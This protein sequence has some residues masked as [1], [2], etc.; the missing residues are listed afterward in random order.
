MMTKPPIY[1]DKEGTGV[2]GPQPVLLTVISWVA[3]CGSFLVA[4][5]LMAYLLPLG[6]LGGVISALAAFLIV[7]LGGSALRLFSIKTNLRYQLAF[8]LSAGAISVLWLL[9]WSA[10]PFWVLLINLCLAWI[11]ALCGGLFLTGRGA[12][13]WENNFPPSTEVMTEVYQRHLDVIGTPG[14]EPKSIRV[15]DILLAGFG[16]LLSAPLWLA[17]SLL[18]WL[19]DPGPLL[20]VKNSVG[21]GG[22]NFHQFKLRTMV[23]GAEEHTGPILAS[24]ADERVLRS[25]R[26][27][28]KSALDELPQL[29][30]ILIGEMSFVGPRPQRTVLVRGYLDS[31]PSYAERHRVLPGL[32]GLAQV[33]GDYYLTPLQ[34]LRFD[35]L[36]I[37]YRSLGYNIKLIALAFVITFWY[38]W[39]RRWDGRLPRWMIRFANPKP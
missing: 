39:H 38:R 15:F 23:S 19:E 3:L 8:A 7:I 12:R 35:R 28:R 37:H 21:K 27:L 11:G 20:F 26:L 13:W 17:C 5:L 22:V 18:I 29:L 25:G 34:K 16:L 33:A 6:I 1:V 36:Y 9:S 4:W 32:A 14:P 2:N 31:I 10:L 24:E 30:N